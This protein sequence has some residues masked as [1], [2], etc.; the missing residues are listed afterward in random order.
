MAAYKNGWRRM[1]T[2]KDEADA[3]LKQKNK[4][5]KINIAVMLL[6]ICIIAILAAISIN[7]K[8]TNDARLADGTVIRMANASGFIAN[9][10]YIPDL[11]YN[12]SIHISANAT[13]NWTIWKGDKMVA[14]IPRGA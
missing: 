2:A 13:E 8:I 3:I 9:T 14:Y 7:E 1:M 10:S 11:Q 12:R 5:L 6:V 4:V